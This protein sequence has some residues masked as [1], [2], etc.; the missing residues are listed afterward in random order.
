M[1]GKLGGW[2]QRYFAVGHCRNTLR[3]ST[4]GIL[5]GWALQGYSAAGHCRDT[6]RLG[7]AGILC[8]WALQEYVAIEHCSQA[9]GGGRGQHRL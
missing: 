8:G 6:L 2:A 1:A 4:A 9:P 5:G 7:T 3:L